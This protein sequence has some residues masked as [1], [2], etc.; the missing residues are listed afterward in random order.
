M[1]ALGFVLLA[2][3]FT[4][5]M[6][7]AK[8]ALKKGLKERPFLRNYPKSKRVVSLPHV[9]VWSVKNVEAS[10]A[11]VAALARLP[12]LAQIWLIA[13]PWGK[14]AFAQANDG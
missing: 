12:G 4:W 9:I 5:S 8:N 3:I 2:I 1:F 11:A 13:F 7:P 6:P 14:V 10:I